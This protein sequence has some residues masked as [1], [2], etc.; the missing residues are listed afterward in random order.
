M[1]EVAFMGDDLADVAVMREAGF[2]A[3]P[4]DAHPWALQHA[5]WHSVARGGEVLVKVW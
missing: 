1:D 2:A 4:G 5:H 3:A